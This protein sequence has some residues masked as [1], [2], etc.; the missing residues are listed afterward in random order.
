MQT[1]DQALQERD[2]L[3]QA[4][5]AMLAAAEAARDAAVDRLLQNEAEQIIK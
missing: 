5:A 1:R 3:I 2:N 4:Q